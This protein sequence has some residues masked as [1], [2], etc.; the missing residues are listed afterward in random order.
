MSKEKRGL[1]SNPY[2]NDDCTGKNHNVE[3]GQN[4]FSKGDKTGSRESQICPH[5]KKREKPFFSKTDLDKVCLAK[6]NF[7]NLQEEVTSFQAMSQTDQEAALMIIKMI[8]T[9]IEK[10]NPFRVCGQPVRWGEYVDQI[11]GITTEGL[12]DVVAAYKAAAG[13]VRNTKAYV[14][15]LAYQVLLERP[16]KQFKPLAKADDCSNIGNFPQREYSEDFFLE[17]YENPVYS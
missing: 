6:K 11:L 3:R 15:S 8:Q 10:G 7:S 5:N 2:I 13:K 16:L 12:I 9:A 4:R 14:T 17:L 1:F